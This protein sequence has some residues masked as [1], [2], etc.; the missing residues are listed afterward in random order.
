M[1]KQTQSLGFLYNFT[2]FWF[3]SFYITLIICFF[4]IYFLLDV[5][6]DNQATHFFVLIWPSDLKVNYDTLEVCYVYSDLIFMLENPS[7]DARLDRVWDVINDWSYRHYDFYMM[8]AMWYAAFYWLRFWYWY[9]KIS[10]LG[11]N[12]PYWSCFK[13]LCVFLAIVM[14]RV[15]VPKFKIESL[16]K[17]GWF[18]S[19][20]WIVILVIVYLIGWGLF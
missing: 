5:C 18:Y 19:L 10:I 6:V 17:T 7:F 14:I 16:S 13:L 12:S 4:F 11:I 3:C 15:T 20:L 1:Q 9:H 2:A 8:H